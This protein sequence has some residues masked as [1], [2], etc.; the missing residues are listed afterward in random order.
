MEF[1]PYIK[2][3]AIRSIKDP[4]DVASI[5]MRTKISKIN[6]IRTGDQITDTQKQIKKNNETKLLGKP[7][8]LRIPLLS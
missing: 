7:G 3:M 8:I 2:K 5:E 6:H 1:S 4:F